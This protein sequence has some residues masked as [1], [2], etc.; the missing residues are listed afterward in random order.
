MYNTFFNTGKNVYTHEHFDVPIFG[1]H[2]VKLSI[3]Q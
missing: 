1:N 2:V 3:V